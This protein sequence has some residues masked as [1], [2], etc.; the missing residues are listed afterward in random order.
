LLLP[1]LHPHE[2][3]AGCDEAGRGCI[4]GPVCAAAVILPNHFFH[5]LLN[6]SKQ[7]TE[8]NRYLL[9][10]I[11]EKEAVAFSVAFV[12]HVKIDQINILQASFLAM[13]KAIAKL[14]RKPTFLLI[15]GNRFKPYKKIPHECIVKGDGKYASIAAASILAKTYRDDFMS[16]LH[17]RFPSYDW[18]QNKGYPTAAHRQAVMDFGMSNYHRK[19]FACVPRQLEISF[20]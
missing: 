8:E 16:Q 7:L 12:N 5:P 17:H 20:I 3:E 18:K 15:D 2:F 9:R 10:P 19:T 6:D 13:H 11:I 14:D 4:A 1:Y